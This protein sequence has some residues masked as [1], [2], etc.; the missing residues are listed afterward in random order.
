[1]NQSFWVPK[2]SGFVDIGSQYQNWK[3]NNQSRYHLVGLQIDIPLFAGFTNHNKIRMAQLDVRNSQLNH[4]MKSKQLDMSLQVAKNELITAYQNYRSSEK[5]LEA[6]RSYQRLIDKGYKEGG[7]TF[8][9]TVDARTQL[10]SAKLK[11]IINHY[12]ILIADAN[13]ERESASFPINN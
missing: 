7:S 3:F 12:R 4:S 6:A 10:T 11:S 9:E 5:Q 1:M 13:Y 8:I 2:I